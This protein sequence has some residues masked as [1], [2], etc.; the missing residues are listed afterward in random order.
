MTSFGRPERVAVAVALVAWVGTVVAHLGPAPHGDAGA[1]GPGD[2]WSAWAAVGVG[3]A[4]APGWALMTAAMMIPV[5]LPAARHVAT[6]SLR[7]RRDRAVALYLAA[8]LGLWTVFGVVAVAGVALWNALVAPA[9]SGLLLSASIVL[10]LLWHVSPARRR[11]VGRCGRAVP[12]PA[13]GWRASAGSMRFGAVY[14]MRCIGSCWALMLIMATATHGHLLWTAA[15]TVLLVAERR[16]PA[17]RRA[18]WPVLASAAAI[19]LVATLPAIA[20][21]PGAVEGWFCRV[22]LA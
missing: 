15:M 2:P 10:A 8:Y 20:S 13:R 9:W 14:G 21:E 12:L 6:S 7:R 5:A 22:G 11:L 3:L 17:V 1:I 19:A 18:P 4:A 16:V